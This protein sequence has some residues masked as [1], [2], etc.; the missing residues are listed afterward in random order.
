MPARSDEPDDLAFAD[1]QIHPVV[2]D[3]P[4][5]PLGESVDL[6]ERAHFKTASASTATSPALSV[7]HSRTRLPSGSGSP[8]IANGEMS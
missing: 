5:K 6:E 1:V 2:R 3:Q 4:S 8:S 7:D